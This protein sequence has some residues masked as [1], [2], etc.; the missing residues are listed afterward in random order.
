MRNYKLKPDEVVRYQGPIHLQTE[1]ETIPAELILTNQNFIFVTEGKKWLWFKKKTKVVAFA[2]ELV[3]TY[4]D[5]PEIKQ[6]GTGVL[7]S[8]AKEDRIL[9]FADKKEAR[10]F[11]INA[12]EIVTGKGIFE[13]G[14]DKLKQA[15][16]LIDEKLD[17]NIIEL[18]KGAITA[19][20]QVATA[21]LF[22]GAVQKLLPKKKK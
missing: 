6:K 8:F 12:W 16:D 10:I 18:V 5:A 11:T 20:T 3:K 17:L 9:V 4:N 19:G 14:L 22:Q 1:K 2:K 13:R 15:L 21:N 7:I